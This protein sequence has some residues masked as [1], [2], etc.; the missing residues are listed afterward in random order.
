[1]NKFTPAILFVLLAAAATPAQEETAPT[2][3]NTFLLVKVSDHAKDTSVKV[4]TSQE[5]K[6]LCGEIA[7]EGRAWEKAMAAAEKEWK[8]NPETAKKSFPR[9]SIGPKKATVSQQFTS[10]D[11][12]MATVS[13]IE[14][15][16]AD[17]SELD[18]KREDEK[19]KNKAK[20]KGASAK[21]QESKQKSEEQRNEMLESARSLFESK[22]AEAMGGE[23]PAAAAAP[24][25]QEKPASKKK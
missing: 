5:Y 19:N 15:R 8:A 9:N 25:A 23:A 16:S 12:A 18:K 21:S 17:Q 13:A 1:M 11:K 20:T 3:G 7:A 2:A 14:K 24:A 10:Q 4:M 6:A 22:L